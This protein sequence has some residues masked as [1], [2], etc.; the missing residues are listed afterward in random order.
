MLNE[1]DDQNRAAA[2][3]SPSSRVTRA[4]WGI[5]EV[6]NSWFHIRF[7]K[8]LRCMLRWL[9]VG[10]F[11]EWK[12]RKIVVTIT[13]KHVSCQ[14]LSL[15]HIFSLPLNLRHLVSFPHVVCF[16]KNCF[17]LCCNTIFHAALNSLPLAWQSCLARSLAVIL[18]CHVW[19]SEPETRKRVYWHASVT[20]HFGKLTKNYDD[21]SSL[22]YRVKLQGSAEFKMMGW[23]CAQCLPGETVCGPRQ[24]VLFVSF[25]EV[26]REDGH[27]GTLWWSCLVDCF[28]PR[29]GCIDLTVN[30]SKRVVCFD[31][32]L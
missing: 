28:R 15:K 4:V 17:C 6:K 3:C 21:C 25:E 29:C 22:G 10:F 24:V 12:R 30:E 13:H 20:Q 18:C 2:S 16:P 1:L 14:I 9:S 5:V 7:S 32:Q 31:A 27:L 19:I 8:E 11:C 26:L 23:I